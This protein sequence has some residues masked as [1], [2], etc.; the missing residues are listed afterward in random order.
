MHE[1]IVEAKKSQGSPGRG[2]GSCTD[3]HGGGAGGSG[4]A[5]EDGGAEEEHEQEEEEEE[6]EEWLEVGKGGTKAVV[7]APDP[8]RRSSNSSVVRRFLV[9]LAVES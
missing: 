8:Q 6:E 2:D 9:L 4:A 5:E 3:A 7:N 1:E